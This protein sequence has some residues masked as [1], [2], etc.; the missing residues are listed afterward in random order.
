MRRMQQR[1]SMKKRGK[2]IVIAIF[3]VMILQLQTAFAGHYGKSR[4]M[5]PAK[6]ESFVLEYGALLLSGNSGRGE[7][8]ELKKELAAQISGG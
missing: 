2:V 5:L 6:T 7:V 1:K 4:D 3:A 8:L